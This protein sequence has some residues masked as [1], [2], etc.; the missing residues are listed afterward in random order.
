MRF[1]EFAKTGLPA[2]LAFATVL[3]EQP[4]TAE[5]LTQEESDAHQG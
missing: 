3:T 5:D 2:L 1:E 4:A